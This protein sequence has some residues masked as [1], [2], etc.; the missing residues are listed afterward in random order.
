MRFARHHREIS[1][2]P[3]VESILVKS[4]IWRLVADARPEQDWWSPEFHD[5][6][7]N[8]QLVGSFGKASGV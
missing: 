7:T 6:V 3:V 4:V 2:I 5:Y 8:N 1:G